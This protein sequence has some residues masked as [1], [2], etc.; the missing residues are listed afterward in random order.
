VIIQDIRYAARTLRRNIL[1]TTVAVVCLSLAIGLNT[2]I[3]SII[4]GVLIQPLPF[5]DP[6]RL[7]E[8]NESHPPSGIRR[9]GLSY[10]D[11]RDWRE[12][13][14][15]FTTI[16]G[17]QLRSVAIADRGDS[18][19]Y[20]AAAVSWDLFSTLGVVPALGRDFGPDDDRP[21]GEP[22]VLLSDEVWRARY[23]GDPA[24][25]GRPLLVNG[26]PHTIIGVMPP[27]FEFPLYQ[28][29]WVPLAPFAHNEPRDRRSLMTVARLKPGVSILQSQDDLRAIAADLSR[30]FPTTNDRWAAVVRPIKA[31]FIPDDVRLILLTMMGAVTLVLV[32]A[33]ANVGNLLLARATA[34]RREISIR[35]A[36]GAGRL[37]IAR[38]L[39]TEA[40]MLSLL[41][42]PP[43][44]ALAHVGN[45]L[46]ERSIPPDDIPYLIQW[47]INAP[48]L[49]YTIGIALLTGI[50]FGLAPT[51][52]TARM[53]LI[54]GL[55]EGGRGTGGTGPRA[56]L[57]NALVVSEVALS[58]VLLI[59]ASLFV[60][61]FL[62]LRTAS[63]G[64]DTAPLMTMRLYMTGDAYASED[65]RA[66]RADEIVRGIE[67]LPGVAA[68]F[69]SNLIPLDGG[70]GGGRLVLDGRTF[71][72]GEE[73][74]FGF[75]AVTPHLLKTLGVPLT[76]GRGF[77]DAE[78]QSRSPVAIINETMA[79]RFWPQEDPV[80][81]RFALKEAEVT[82]WFTVIGVVRD[83][84]HDE[85]EPDD[86]SFP[87]SYVPYPYAATPNT[88]LTIR[89]AS[90]DPSAIT[91]AVR[92]EIR[93]LDAGIPLFA[94]RSMAEVKRLGFWQF[95]LFG[96]LFSTFGAVALLLAVAGVYG[97]LS[98]SVSQ[99]TQEIGV[100]VALG[101][102]RGAVVRLVVGQGLKLA[103][104][105]VAV[106]VLASFGVTRVIASQLYNVTPTDPASFVGVSLFLA[107]IAA[108]ASYIPAR[109]ATAVD[110]LDALRAE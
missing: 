75:T 19:R 5:A 90:D 108:A 71:P 109:R 47:D 58:L 54:A 85:I 39:L 106:G 110:P 86:E 17:I 50:V 26:R 12:R 77:T 103:G 61:S 78:G 34:R 96:W 49:L 81:R 53:N 11:L 72:P 66:R 31:D 33:C 60:R 29:I 105:G 10:A 24:I 43:G 27:D 38:Q 104:L 74:R 9:T 69:A 98:Y 73:P 64:F 2:M 79:I 101:A 4:E 87:Q 97:L 25:V 62:N 93:R 28:K 51:L 67:R 82:D 42:V 3:F 45:L 84:R 88:G 15:S 41:A 22:V 30:D 57:R 65:A 23:G 102:D 100:R 91:S 94:V 99:R 92:R 80:G 13:N 107:V 8:L 52:Q 76:R 37:R 95:E 55:K 46:V 35:T 6:D 36:L 7:V 48:V 40:V 68:A 83:I 59:G 89:V 14:R 32:I 63:A 44:V 21:A 70:G 20:D 18:E 1:F 56:R 16:V